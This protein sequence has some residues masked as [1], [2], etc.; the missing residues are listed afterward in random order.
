MCREFVKWY[1]ARHPIKHTIYLYGPARIYGM[2]ISPARRGL[3]NHEALV[4]FLMLPA[5]PRGVVYTL[6][7]ELVHYE[8]Y[9]SRRPINERNVNRRSAA[10]VRAW[11]RDRSAG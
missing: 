5:R 6:A 8:Q 4:I 3:E 1:T 11:R 10:L 9:R 2:F 7:H